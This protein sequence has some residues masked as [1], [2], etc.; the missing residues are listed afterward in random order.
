MTLSE[1]IRTIYPELKNQ[2]LI[3]NGILLQND[4]DGKGDYIADW[5]HLTLAQPTD[6]QLNNIAE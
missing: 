5:R 2:P 4:S 3:F 6:E 1:K